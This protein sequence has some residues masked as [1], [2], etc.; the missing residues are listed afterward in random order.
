MLDNVQVNGQSGTRLSAPGYQF[1][2][3][4]DLEGR[5]VNLSDFLSRV[6]GIQIQQLSGLGHPAL[7]SIR[8]ASAQQTRVLINGI[9]VS[10]AQN[11]AYDLNQ[12]PVS[13]ID[14][15]EVLS[16]GSADRAIG[17]TVN[18]ITR[19]D[20]Q[21]QVMLQAGSYG[22]LSTAVNLPLNPHTSVRLD[23][24]QSAN[25]YPYPVP[26]PAYD[27]QNLNHKETLNNDAYARTAVQI[28]SAN[29]IG[30]G[31][32]QL[33]QQHKEMAD[34]QR[35]NP[36]NNAWLDTQNATL[37]INTTSDWLGMQQSWTA[38]S[39]YR[40]ERYR[41]QQGLIGLGEDDNR[42]RYNKYYLQLKSSAVLNNFQ[43]ELTAAYHEENYQSRY[44]L[45]DDSASCTT[46][47][48]NCDTLSNQQLTNIGS[49]LNWDS[50][51]RNQHAYVALYREQRS[52]L[53]RPAHQFNTDRSSDGFTGGAA[54][55]QWFGGD[56]E[57]SLT[58]KHAARIPT[59]YERYGD[60]GLFLANS[61]LV[62]E[63]SSTWSASVLWNIDVQWQASTSL[64][65]RQLDN[66]IVPVYD[67]RGIGR[68]ENTS[69]ATLNGLEWNIAYCGKFFYTSVAG[70]HY[71]STTQ[72]DIRSFNNKQL[73][74]TYHTSLKAMTGIRSGTHTLE[75]SGELSDNLYID[76]SNLVEGDTRSLLNASYRY[77]FSGNETGLK[78][79]NLTNHH[80]LDFTNRPTIG[81]E[82]LIFINIHFD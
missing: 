52:E 45:D 6:N 72:S 7:I 16:D 66:A 44:L 5:F 70:S 71:D 51:N 19:Q 75:I 35:N 77:A 12:L 8:G 27:S 50:R 15:I 55:Y 43:A 68:Y 25:N 76:R 23:H 37:E 58:Y 78:I 74:G 26:S 13:Q 79:S 53:S 47:Q 59:L 40:D 64:F 73:P 49:A 41:D 29:H 17:G 32:L 82:W 80:F 61:D 2:S 33:S 3:R 1:F 57:W 34:Y 63:I 46:A 21:Q 54:G 11:G 48:G 20:N 10:S 38:G 18:I 39:D 24:Q 4:A 42:Y 62:A 60:H 69:A 67:S 31:R 9:E 22:T 56:S 36:H 81:R 28:Q 14:S 65:R 30:S